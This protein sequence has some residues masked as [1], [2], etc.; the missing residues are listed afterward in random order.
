MKR[1]LRSLQDGL[2]QIAVYFTGEIKEIFR[3]SGTIVMFIIAMIAYPVAYALGYINET[4]KDIPVAIVDK[5][6][7][8]MSMKLSRMLNATEQ[9]KI[10]YTVNNLQDAQDLF[11]KNAVTG[12]VL[13]DKDFEKN[14]LSGRQGVISIYSDASHFLLYKQMYSGA[15]YASQ[16]LGAGIEVRNL[17]SKGK[18]MEQ[19][20]Q[21][22][23]PLNLQVMNL[24]NP[25]G[26]YATFVVPAILVILIQQTLLIGIGILYGKHNELKNYHYLKS[27]V[28]RPFE[29]M[30]IVLG[31]TLAFMS[32]YLVTSFLML[33]LFYYFVH[34][35]N[36]GQFANIYFVLIPYLAAVS[37]LGI[38]IGLLMPKR[39]YGLLCLVFLSPAILFISGAVWPAQMLPKLLYV[40]SYLLPSTPMVAAFIR[41]RVMNA[42]LSSIH[43]EY[44][45]LIIQMIAYFILAVFIYRIKL[46]RLRK[47]MV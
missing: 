32:I 10:A 2:N 27:G 25:S 24:Y 16:T 17:L 23:D 22:R 30:K 47:E 14:I 9:I 43:H 21:Q 28:R 35:P 37:F 15:V 26:G 12:V 5:D 13:I 38:A 18:T 20:L 39:I 29:G 31:Q 7:T 11:Y 3:D 41:L 33:G 19:A 46:H 8:N 44:S 4:A 34:F 6:H 45:I 42:G 40:V 36:K 1:L